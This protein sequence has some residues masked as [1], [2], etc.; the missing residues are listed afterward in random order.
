MKSISQ[1]TGTHNSDNVAGYAQYDQRFFD[2]LSVSAGMRAE[3]YRVDDF[4]K[5][6]ET[7]IFGVKVP[8]KPIFRAGVNYQIGR[9]SCRERVLRLV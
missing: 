7:D 6:A 3:Y 2:K 9:A 4:R 1:T 8:V 5:E